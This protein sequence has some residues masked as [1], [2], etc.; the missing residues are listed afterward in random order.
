[1]N[2]AQQSSNPGTF[3]TTVPSGAPHRLLG[4]LFAIPTPVIFVAAAAVATIVLWRQGSLGNVGATLRA[5]SPWSLVAILLAYGVGILLLG[6]RWHTLVRLAGG[7]PAWSNSADV[8]L[9]SV[10]VNYAAPIGLAVPTRA[11]L[12]VRDL[13]LTRLQS[14]FV[15]G[16]EVALDV[17]TLSAISAAWLALGGSAAIGEVSTGANRITSVAPT[18]IVLILIATVGLVVAARVPAVRRRL[19]AILSPMLWQPV[20]NPPIALLA[21]ALTV[22]YWTTQL[23]VMAALT[24]MFGISTSP[25]LVLG[26]MGLP[27]LI[28]MLSPVPGGAGIRE[29]LMATVAR[30]AG[31]AAGPVVLAAIAY[32]LALFVVTPAVWGVLRVTKARK[33]MG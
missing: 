31:V 7:A 13:G 22:V 3:A 8:F 32:R 28:G 29:A 30:F 24:A 9:T 10:I 6:L 11:A 5:V 14:G 26:L 2:E 18:I 19:S 23:G 1:M 25:S 20:R 21:A 16:W 17:L 15:V 33:A 4:P 27:V 12:T